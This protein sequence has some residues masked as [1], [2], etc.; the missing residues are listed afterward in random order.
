VSRGVMLSLCDRTTAMA[1][2][3][4]EAGFTCYCVDV[5]HEPGETQDGN[6]IR[7]GA[8]LMTWLPPREK[9]VFVAAFPPCTNLAVSGARWFASKGL[10]GLAEGLLLVERCEQIAEW[11]GAP[12][13][14]ENP[15]STISSYW[16]KPD[17]LF[18]PYQYGGYDGGHDDGYTKKTCLWTGGGFVMPEVKEIDLADDHDRI[19]KAAPSP[20]RG[21]IRAATPMGFAQAVFQANVGIGVRG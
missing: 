7:V 12:W 4:A 8:D 18:H 15:V 10:R 2:P 6:I 19:W 5:Q 17:H 21:D 20:D 14:I 9:I 3:W 1:Q 16:R 13:F 11:S